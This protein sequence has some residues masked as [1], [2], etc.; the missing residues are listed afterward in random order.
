MEKLQ[1]Q[2]EIEFEIKARVE[3]KINELL[4]NLRNRLRHKYG[5]AFDMTRE[6][7]RELTAFREVEKAFRE[8][9]SVARREIDLPLP[10][11]SML[12]ESKRIAKDK[13]VEEMSKVLDIR[14][15]RDYS[16]KIR[17]IVSIIEEA[18]NY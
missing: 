6:S 5:Q 10:A 1:T 14:K 2:T 15:E 16:Y 13:S 18:Q 12:E 4:T 11:I 3:F 8:V 17:K 7:D 9:V